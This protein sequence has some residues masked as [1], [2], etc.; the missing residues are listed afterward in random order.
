MLIFSKINNKLVTL[1]SSLT[2]FRIQS[3]FLSICIWYVFVFVIQFAIMFYLTPP[4]T[5]E[6]KSELIFFFVENPM[7]YL[8]GLLLGIWIYKVDL[9]TNS[10][11][12]DSNILDQ[13]E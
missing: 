13:I 1:S 4:E 6:M 5:I 11:F 3:S 8:I 7:K 2:Q 10:D 9:K 12:Q